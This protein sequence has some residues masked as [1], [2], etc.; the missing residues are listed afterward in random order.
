MHTAVPVYVSLLVCSSFDQFAGVQFKMGQPVQYVKVSE[1][2]PLENS[3]EAHWHDHLTRLLTGGPAQQIRPAYEDGA[4][5]MLCLLLAAYAMYFMFWITVQALRH[6]DRQLI[7]PLSLGDCPGITAGR[8]QPH[9]RA[10]LIV[11]SSSRA[12]SNILTIDCMHDAGLRMMIA[13][14]DSGLLLL[15]SLIDA[16]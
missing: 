4:V 11:M 14:F 12:I 5:M 2:N 3:T 13:G 10:G 15:H 16:W 1:R 7:D 8:F 9:Q 6:Q